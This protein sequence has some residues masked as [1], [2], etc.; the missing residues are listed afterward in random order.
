MPPRENSDGTP[1]TNLAGFEIRYGRDRADLSTVVTLD[2]PTLS[3]YVVENLS[4]GTWYFAVAALNSN[5]VA[6]DLSNV[7]SKTIT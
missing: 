7:T 5:G 1:L 3:V 6:S 2:D 4:G